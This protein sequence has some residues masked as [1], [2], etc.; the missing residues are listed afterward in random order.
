MSTAA[1]CKNEVITD[2]ALHQHASCLCVCVCVRC[3]LHCRVCLYLEINPFI[4]FRSLRV[5][6]PPLRFSCFLIFPYAD[7]LPPSLLSLCFLSPL[8]KSFSDASVAIVLGYNALTI[9]GANVTSGAAR[10]I[11]VLIIYEVVVQYYCYGSGGVATPTLY[12]G[13]QNVC[14][15]TEAGLCELEQERT[16]KQTTIVLQMCL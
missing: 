4:L 15:Y 10:C 13:I 7:Y 2:R 1:I 9:R 11:R 14:M 6:F 12:G 8:Y 5:P 3:M 16:V